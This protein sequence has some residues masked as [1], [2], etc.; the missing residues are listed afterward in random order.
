[1]QQLAE[2]FE[3]MLED[4]FCVKTTLACPAFSATLDVQELRRIF[5]NL[6]SNVQKYA[7]PDKPVMLSISIENAQLII[8]QENAIRKEDRP[9]EGYQIGLRSIQRI[10][11][12][13]GGRVEI[14]QNDAAFA[15][16]IALSDI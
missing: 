13:Y 1:M 10:A 11:Q 8:W 3:P 7:A 4:T 2:E 16:C 5:D 12:N 9:T 6:I 14:Q 15:I